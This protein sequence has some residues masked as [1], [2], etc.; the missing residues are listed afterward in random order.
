M[1]TRQLI[2]HAFKS[3]ATKDPSKTEAK[4]AYETPKAMPIGTAQQ[5]LQGCWTYATYKDAWGSYYTYT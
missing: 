3:E 5:L 2:S 4:T 1:I